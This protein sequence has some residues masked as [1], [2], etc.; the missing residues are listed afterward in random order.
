ML[1]YVPE[2]KV[3]IQNKKSVK[4]YFLPKIFEMVKL[5]ASRAHNNIISLLKLYNLAFFLNDT[6]LH[7]CSDSNPFRKPSFKQNICLK[8]N[9]EN[10]S[11]NKEKQ[12][13]KA[14]FHKN[15]LITVARF[16]SVKPFF[17]SAL[18]QKPSLW[19]KKTK[20]LLFANTA[21]HP[22]HFSI[23]KVQ[24]LENKWFL[25]FSFLYKKEAKKEQ[26]SK[27]ALNE[28]YKLRFY[29]ILNKSI[30]NKIIRSSVAHLSINASNRWNLQRGPENGCKTTKRNMWFLNNDSVIKQFYLIR[31]EHQKKV[32]SYYKAYYHRLLTSSKKEYDKMFSKTPYVGN[33]LADL[34]FFINPEKDKNLTNQARNLQ[35]PTMGIVSGTSVKRLG[36]K[37][38]VKTYGLED[39]VS[40]PIL[41]NPASRSFIRII[42]NLIIKLLQQQ[43]RFINS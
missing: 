29:M 10:T 22:H 13:E 12:L 15:H 6:A 27:S 33:A 9:D 24:K 31:Q 19:Y 16:K 41:G 4:L 18:P 35:I 32:K 34:I 17:Y 2:E 42:L 43:E 5:N 8:R 7:I 37:H 23:E 39:C 25:T 3:K 11:L 28:F 20:K 21:R 30:R 36:K 14:N 38:N 1:S 40:Y 26:Q